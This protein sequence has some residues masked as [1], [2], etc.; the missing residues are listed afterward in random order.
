M[1]RIILAWYTRFDIFAGLLGG[2][3]MVLDRK[4]FL[5]SETFLQQQVAEEPAELNWRIESASAK[6]RRIA[7]DMITH[8]ANYGKGESSQDQFL[9]DNDSIRRMLNDWRINLDPTL[10]DDRFLV[11]EYPDAPVDP[12]AVFD[13]YVPGA[14]YHGPLWSMNIILIDWYSL[15]VMHKYQTAL[16]LKTDPDPEIYAGAFT[17]CRLFETVEYFPESPPGTTLC[18]HAALAIAFI[19]LPRDEK[20]HMWA[21]RKLASIECQG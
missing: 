16:F 2:W 8:F 3:E 5:Y 14:I 6:L 18:L 15:D 20:H 19:F 13:R 1:S 10:Q 12:N 7:R 17:T 21:R 4:W 11:T 9:K